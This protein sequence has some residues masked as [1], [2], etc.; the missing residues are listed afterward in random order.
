MGSPLVVSA[1]NHG[2]EPRPSGAIDKHENI[3]FKTA[4]SPAVIAETF[5]FYCSLSH[6]I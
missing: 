2:H 1:V 5:S 4:V 6:L 3:H